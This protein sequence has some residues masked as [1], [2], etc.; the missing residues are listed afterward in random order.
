MSVY[1]LCGLNHFT[2]KK[3]EKKNTT[4]AVPELTIEDLFEDAFR[5]LARDGAGNI[6]VMIRLQEA[7]NSVYAIDNSAIK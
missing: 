1:F 4:V 2:R 7:F 3:T 6:E 5:P